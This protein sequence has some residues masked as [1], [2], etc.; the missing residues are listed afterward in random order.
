M[1]ASKPGFKNLRGSKSFFFMYSASLALNST[2]NSRVAFANASWHNRLFKDVSQFEEE[3]TVLEKKLSGK[4]NSTKLRR[5]LAILLEK[6][7]AMEKAMEYLRQA[8]YLG[9][10]EASAEIDRL[11]KLIA[12]R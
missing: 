11:E 7:G 4:P 6:N 1:I 8:A 12:R 9:D 5:D 10:E 2:T 3:R